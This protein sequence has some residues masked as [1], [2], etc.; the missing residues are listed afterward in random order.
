MLAIA[1]GAFHDILFLLKW[2]KSPPLKA[3]GK[4]TDLH[5]NHDPYGGNWRN[6]SQYFTNLLQRMIVLVLATGWPPHPACWIEGRWCTRL[7]LEV[8][9]LECSHRRGWAWHSAK[10]WQMVT[11]YLCCIC[12]SAQ[13][14]KIR[15]VAISWFPWIRAMDKGEMKRMTMVW[16][17][18]WQGLNC[19]N[20]QTYQG[21]RFKLQFFNFKASKW[22]VQLLTS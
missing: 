20:N 7:P 22:T 2:Q 4:S 5:F 1:V 11:M 13:Y 17:P 19:L 21:N 6:M 14:V 15:C 3:H 9:E 8:L 12:Q 18:G 16:G 10:R